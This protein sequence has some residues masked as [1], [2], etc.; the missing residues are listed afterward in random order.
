M[1]GRSEVLGG[2]VYIKFVFRLY[3]QGIYQICFPVVFV[4][5]MYCV[6]LIRRSY[7]TQFHMP[8]SVCSNTVVTA[9][10]LVMHL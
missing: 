9:D 5:F 6:Q 8:S 10:A 7:Y 3:L 4:P 2:R 1:P